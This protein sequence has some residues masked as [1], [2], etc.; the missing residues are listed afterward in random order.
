MDFTTIENQYPDIETVVKLSIS[1]AYLCEYTKEPQS[2]KITVSYVPDN[3]FIGLREV[4]ALIDSMLDRPM[5]LETLTQEIS[6]QLCDV[7]GV[8]VLTEA[9]YVLSG[10][11]MMDVEAFA[12]IL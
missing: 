1:R 10:G 11:V 8:P 2:T 3:I 6:K 4:N 5:D 9:T 7:L 12:N